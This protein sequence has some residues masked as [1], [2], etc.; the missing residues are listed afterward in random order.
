MSNTREHKKLIEVALPLDEINA[1][2][3]ADKDRKTG[4]IR[5]LHKWF[6]PMPLPAWRALLF[7]ALVDDPADDEKRAYLLDV[8]KRLVASGANVPD[9]A[10]VKEA[11]EIIRSQFPDGLPT[12]MDPFCGGGST[13]VEAQ[14]LGLPTF[15]SDLNPVPALIS[16]TLT[17]LLPKIFGRQ[18]LHPD[19]IETPTRRGARRS[20]PAALTLDDAPPGT[21]TY[22]S[23]GGLARDVTHYAEAIAEDTVRELTPYYPSLPGETPVAWLW[24]RTVT[25]P[26]PACGIETVLATS[27]SLSKK[28]DAFAWIQPSVRDG[29]VHLDVVTGMRYDGTPDAPKAGR[30]AS[31]TCLGCRSVIKEDY[32]AS[33]GQTGGLGLRM[34]CVVANRDQARVHRAPTVEDV[35]AA[36]QVPA[37]D[38]FPDLALPNIARWFSGPRFGLRTQA[39]QYTRR[40]LQILAATADAVA[41]VHERLL[42]D[43]ADKT[44]ADVVTTVLGLA[45]GR[46]AQYQSSQVRWFIDSRSGTG[47]ALPAFGRHDMP[48]QWDFAEPAPTSAAGSLTGAVKSI[49]AGVTQAGTGDGMVERQDARVARAPGPSL[50]ATD[51]PYFDAIGYADLSDYFYVWHRR[52]L[53]AVHPDLYATMAAPKAGELTAIPAHHGNSSEV[54][55]R[56]FIDGFTET[57]KNLRASLADGLP[58]LVVYASKEQKGGRE[59]ETRWS[60]IL[61][62]IVAAELEITGTWPVLG[63]RDKRMIGLD[64]NSVAAYVVMAC[65]PRTPTAGTCSLADFNRTLRRELKPAVHDLQAAGILPVDLAQAAMGPGMQVYS[66]YREVLDQAGQ[67]VPVEQALRLINAALGEVLDEQEGELDAHSRFAVAWWERNGW[68]AAPFGQADQLARPQGLSVDDVIR[69]GVA[70]HPRPGFVQV[71]GVVGLDREWKPSSDRTP[72]A[73][74]TVHH[75]ADRLIDGGGTLE[76]GRL[77]SELGAFRDPAQA[78]VYRLHAIAAKKGW[79]KDQERYNALIGSWSDLLAVAATEK[80]GLF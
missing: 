60:S 32:V 6:A 17:D 45:V 54:A 76:A 3:K 48:M 28:K 57:F 43:G 66:R 36:E 23:F 56:Y 33:E 7:A 20:E 14:R 75:L 41:A 37:V 65:R 15:G 50:V 11:R 38:D 53:R 9:D 29:V 24:A 49:L 78:L 31:F 40:Q 2:C 63:A 16:R 4:T 77:M 13:L 58:L 79:T 46:M 5:N 61:T 19:Q 1:A 52:A 26:N 68:E 64:T 67:R 62:A 30:G 35:R 44:W 34:T 59:E 27:W 42:S 47:Q 70:E 71:R 69:A 25:C 80:D 18:P 8:I 74:E 39:D 51:P 21:R 72:T 55:R 12:V 73:W 22:D 10:V